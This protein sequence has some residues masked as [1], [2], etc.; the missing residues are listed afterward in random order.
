[1]KIEIEINEADVA[2]IVKTQIVKELHQIVYRKVHDKVQEKV[3][4]LDSEITHAV[5]VYFS[6]RLNDEKIKSMIND[7]AAMIIR[8]RLE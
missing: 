1:M 7:A 8:E 2:E 3:D 4:A 5:E 6:K